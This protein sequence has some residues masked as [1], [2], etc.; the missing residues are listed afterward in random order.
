MVQAISVL[1]QST[2]TTV[3]RRVTCGQYRP[4]EAPGGDILSREK[5]AIVCCWGA[6]RRPAP[7]PPPYGRLATGVGLLLESRDSRLA[8]ELR[9]D[10]G[11][12]ANGAG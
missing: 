1:F 5:E 11:A 10:A 7:L 9:E 12:A 4:G 3:W 2:N 8:R 6:Y